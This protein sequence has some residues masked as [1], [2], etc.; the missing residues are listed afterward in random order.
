MRNDDGM[1]YITVGKLI[2]LLSDVD[3]TLYISPNQVGNLLVFSDE[4]SVY[5][6]DLTEESLETFDY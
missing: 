6:V 4:R 2:E 5:Y 1:K 3:K